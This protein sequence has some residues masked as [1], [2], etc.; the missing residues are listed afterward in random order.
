MWEK[1]GQKNYT[2]EVI[3]DQIILLGNSSG[4]GAPNSTHKQGATSRAS[5]PKPIPESQ[6]E[7]DLDSLDSISDDLPF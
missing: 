2:T 6:Q 1:D 4:S 7:I 3:V 5:H